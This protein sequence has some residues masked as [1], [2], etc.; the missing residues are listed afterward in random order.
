MV[1]SFGVCKAE[2]IFIFCLINYTTLISGVILTTFPRTYF[3][4]NWTAA[5]HALNNIKKQ[6]PEDSSM[7][8][9]KYLQHLI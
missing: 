7:E 4:S 3:P 6:L 2:T 9:G 8:F 5:M 1:S